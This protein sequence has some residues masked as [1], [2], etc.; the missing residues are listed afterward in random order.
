MRR[1][2]RDIQR[3]SRIAMDNESIQILRLQAKI[4]KRDRR[5]EGCERKIRDLEHQLAACKLELPKM[6]HRT[7]QEALANVRMIPV[8]GVGA[9][10]RI[11]V[12]EESK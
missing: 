3:V 5:I 10:K 8:Y 12:I 2:N 11:R 1:R 9:D 4:R 6:L 7:V